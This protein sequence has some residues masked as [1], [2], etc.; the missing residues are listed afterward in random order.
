MSDAKDDAIEGLRAAVDTYKQLAA[1]RKERIE[2]L[3]TELA[4]LR[5]LLHEATAPRGLRAYDVYDSSSGVCR[6]CRM[7][8][9][10]NC[11]LCW[12]G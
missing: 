11:L 4:R 9:G 7:P 8:G 5:W 6:H 1:D 10:G 12:R 3:E 2:R